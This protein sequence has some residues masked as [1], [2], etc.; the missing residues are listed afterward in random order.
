MK[1]IIFGSAE[2]K[3]YSF[4]KKYLQKDAV[5]LCCDG[6]MRHTKALDILP[7]YILGDFD[8]VSPDI[9][10]FY[11]KLKIPIRS[12]PEKKDE[13]DMELGVRFAMEL[14]ITDL[15][16]LGGIGSR[17]DH[18][19]ANCHLL[20]L[21]LKNNI[22]GRLANEKNC[23][24]MIDSYLKITGKKGDLV[25][26]VPACTE[27]S[28]VTLKGMEYPLENATIPFESPIGVSN[29]MTGEEAEIFIKKGLVYVI[30]ARD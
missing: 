2:I 30:Q 9:L 27:V 10:S 4:C 13:T 29:V 16:I 14:G 15:V 28:G 19:L 18:T 23:I 12:F 21:L 11:Q 6:G 26:L 1:G 17:M 7:D 24:E 5:I 8:S 25:S 3:D 20:S 22:R